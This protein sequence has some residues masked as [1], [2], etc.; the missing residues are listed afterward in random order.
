MKYKLIWDGNN[1]KTKYYLFS[2]KYKKINQNF[3]NKYPPLKTIL[4][5]ALIWAKITNNYQGGFLS[6]TK[7]EIHE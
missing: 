6:N 2:T 1:L 7:I 4:S 3:S 5:T